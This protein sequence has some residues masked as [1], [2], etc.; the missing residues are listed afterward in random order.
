VAEPQ[1]S[2]ELV[3]ELRADKGAIWYDLNSLRLKRL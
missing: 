1:R 2:I 3:C